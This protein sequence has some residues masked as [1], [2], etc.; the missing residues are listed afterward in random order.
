ML[1]GSLGTGGTALEFVP[2]R[3]LPVRGR[4]GLLAGMIGTG[5]GAG[6]WT[7]G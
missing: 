2:D 4:R 3:S 5:A 7:D 1:S 6:G